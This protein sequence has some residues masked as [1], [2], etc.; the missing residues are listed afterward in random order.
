MQG[1]GQARSFGLSGRSPLVVA[2]S[3]GADTRFGGDERRAAWSNSIRNFGVLALGL[4]ALFAGTAASMASIWLTSSVYHHGLFVAPLALWL[5][6]QARD[7]R[8]LTPQLD[9]AGV[10]PVAAACFLW[11]FG[12]AAN[13]DAIGHAA[14]VATL[15]GAVIVAFGREI[16][17]RWAL[18][19]CI[20][21]FMAPF[22]EELTPILQYWTSVVAATALSATGVETVRDGFMLTT[23][24]GRFEVAPSCSGLRFLLASALIASAVSYLGFRRWR[25]SLAFIAAALG[26]ALVANWLRAYLIVFAATATERRLGVGPEHVTLGWILYGGLIVG[27]VMIARTSADH[28]SP[29]AARPARQFRR[30]SKFAMPAAFLCAIAAIVWDVAVI[31]R[32]AE[33]ASSATLPTIEAVGFTA[34]T[35]ALVWRPFAPNADRLKIAGYRSENAR[36]TV[37]MAFFTHDRPGAEIAS[38]DVRAADGENWRRIAIAPGRPRVETLEDV[39]G[40]KIDVATLYWLGD[41]VYSSPAAVK[42]DIAVNRFFGRAASGGAIFVGALHAENVAPRAAVRSFLAGADEPW[43]RPRPPSAE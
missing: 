22:G 35:D 7:W 21:F 5:I 15:V 42:F 38:Y 31:S 20:L 2:V 12:R 36:V 13:I 28:P 8:D 11:L 24:A 40:R 17:A 29:V 33:S 1:A 25:K 10:L 32:T 26:A 43:R 6:L 37:S 23:A 41:R 4:I 16:A 18:P 14:L 34:T 19:L 3:S 39:R 30:E 9:I 27:L